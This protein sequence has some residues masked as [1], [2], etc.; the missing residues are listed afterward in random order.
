MFKTE[1]GGIFVLIE[2]WDKPCAYM[3]LE[4]WKICCIEKDDAF[5]FF[6]LLKSA[7]IG[8]FIH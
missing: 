4:V 2:M 8:L 7:L 6:F 5:F 1:F 3:L